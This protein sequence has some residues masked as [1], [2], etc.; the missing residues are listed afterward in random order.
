MLPRL[1]HFNKV[2][3][4]T[5]VVIE[6]AIGRLKGKFQRLKRINTSNTKR[7]RLIIRACLVL[8]NFIIK[9]DSEMLRPTEGRLVQLPS[10]ASGIKKRD[11]ISKML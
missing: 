5:R 4:S 8:H 7:A 9:Y 11:A 10:S 1:A 6:N 2:H 3:T